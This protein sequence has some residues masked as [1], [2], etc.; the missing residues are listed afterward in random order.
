M[1]CICQ[2]AETIRLV[3]IHGIAKSVV[4]IKIGDEVLVHIGPGAT[5]FGTVI[6]ETIIEK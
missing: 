5:H 6:K 2:N 4:D 1:S 3:D